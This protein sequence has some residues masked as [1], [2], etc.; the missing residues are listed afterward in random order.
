MQ[1][2]TIKAATAETA[3]GF[4]S[5]LAGFQAVLNEAEDGSYLVEVTLGGRDR[6]IIA[7]LNALEDY[8]TNRGQG[9]AE[10]ALAGRRYELHPI[11]G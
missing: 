6:E 1:T 8:V 7:L 11:A 9:P 10:V 5:G 2:L 3:H 4:M